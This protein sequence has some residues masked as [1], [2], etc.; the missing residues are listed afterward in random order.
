MT[1]IDHTYTDEPVCPYCGYIHEDDEGVFMVDH[2]EKFTCDECG[3][4]FT[5]YCD[6]KVYYN[7]EK[8]KEAPDA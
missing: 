1:D 3:K 4:E 5:C 8:M 7:T 6:R 2:P